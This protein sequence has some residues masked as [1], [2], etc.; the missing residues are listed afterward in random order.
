MSHAMEGLARS[1][2]DEPGLLWKIWTENEAAGEAGG[3]YVFTDEASARAYL[4]MHAKR[5]EQAGCTA[6]RGKIFDVNAALSKLNRA[7][8]S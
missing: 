7:P 5:L 3:I 6:I 2:S 1:I 8:L 4:D